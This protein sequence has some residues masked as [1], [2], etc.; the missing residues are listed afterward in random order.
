MWRIKFGPLFYCPSIRTGLLL[1][2]DHPLLGVACAK[3]RKFIKQVS[4]L[5]SKMAWPLPLLPLPLL[6]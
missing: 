6:G 5:R 1:T 3:V 4:G 2:T